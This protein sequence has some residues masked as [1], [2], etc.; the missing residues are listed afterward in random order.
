MCDCCFTFNLTIS[1][2]DNSRDYTF[3]GNGKE[4]PVTEHRF[5][6]KPIS[7]EI[8][9]GDT[10][11]YRDLYGFMQG[12]WILK[13]DKDLITEDAIYEN[14]SIEIG[15]T[16]KKYNYGNRL[17]YE[18]EEILIETEEGYKRVY[19]ELFYYPSGNL[20]RKCIGLFPQECEDFPDEPIE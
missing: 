7:F 12:R 2:Y 4:I 5:P 1:G 20:K 16:D 15:K 19:S 13:N 8:L 9:D 14:G 17:I 11:N 18:R 6:L 3:I 10:I